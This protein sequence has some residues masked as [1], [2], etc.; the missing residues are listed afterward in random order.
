MIWGYVQA[1]GGIFL[2]AYG[3]ARLLSHV[4]PSNTLAYKVCAWVLGHVKPSDTGGVTVNPK[5]DPGQVDPSTL[6]A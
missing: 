2:V 1:N 6:G 3:V 4:L 5:I